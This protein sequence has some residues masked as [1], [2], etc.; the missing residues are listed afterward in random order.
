M[1]LGSTISKDSKH[2]KI[3]SWHTFMHF[4][5]LFDLEYSFRAKTEAVF[6]NKNSVIFDFFNV[7]DMKFE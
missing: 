2:Q 6:Q 5:H 1:A 7:D 4:M 3:S